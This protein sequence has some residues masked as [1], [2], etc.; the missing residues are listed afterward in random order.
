MDCAAWSASEEVEVR[1]QWRGSVM[2]HVKR[3]FR[4]NLWQL[5]MITHATWTMMSEESCHLRLKEDVL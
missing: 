3:Y 1:V 4:G 2:V 5:S